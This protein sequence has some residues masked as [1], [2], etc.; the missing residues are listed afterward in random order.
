MVFNNTNIRSSTN[1]GSFTLANG[2]SHSFSNGSFVNLNGTPARVTGSGWVTFDDFNFDV[3]SSNY[4]NRTSV[5]SAFDRVFAGSFTGSLFGTASWATN[6]A[7]AVE[8][9]SYVT[10]LN[11]DVTITGSLTV[12]T[13][14]IILSPESTITG[15]TINQPTLV[16][17]QNTSAQSISNN[18]VPATIIT[19]W[20][21]LFTQNAAE[22]NATTGVFTA[23]KAG[24]YSVSANLTYAS[25]ANTANGQQVNVSIRKN[26]TDQAVSMQITSAATTS[27]RSTG[28]A[29][30][31]VS[32][33]VGDTITI[34]TYH[35]LGNTAT[36]SSQSTVTIQQIASRITH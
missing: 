4:S 7:G 8:T 33:A 6:V 26:T 24:V 18:V 32:L 3:T 10:N 25:V 5:L 15:S 20:T 22:W 14:S 13:G 16:Q 31:V 19:N 2:V 21:N 9:A 36:L 29:T 23:T 12:I 35:N 28:T 27:L 30:A 17:A 1:G 34:R 11:Q